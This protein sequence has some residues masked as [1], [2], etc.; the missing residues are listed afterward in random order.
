MTSHTNVSNFYVQIADSHNSN[1]KYLLYVQF[2]LE[3]TLKCVYFSF[4]ILQLKTVLA[5]FK[6]VIIII[7]KII[8][9][10]VY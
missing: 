8:N 1:N 9:H 7:V 3:F 5:R 2:M 6:Q 4:Q 10:S